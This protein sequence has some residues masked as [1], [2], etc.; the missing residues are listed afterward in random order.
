MVDLI[1]EACNHVCTL[2]HV[3]LAPHH[4]ILHPM[5]IPYVYHLVMPT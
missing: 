1:L 3:P 2:I 5:C 4:D